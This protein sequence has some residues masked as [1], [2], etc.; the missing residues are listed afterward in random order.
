MTGTQNNKPA[1]A[2][3]QSSLRRQRRILLIAVIVTAVLALALV[4]TNFLTSREP[5]YDPVDNTKYYVVKKDGTYVLTATDG[6]VL[7][8]TESTNFVTA[9]GTIVNVDRK[10]GEYAIV[11]TVLV[12]GDETTKFDSVTNSYDVL[13]YPILERAQIKSIEVVNK[14]GG[15]SI[16]KIISDDGVESFVLKNRPDLEVGNSIVFATLI[17][18]TG[19]TQTLM[20]LDPDRVLGYEEYGLDTETTYFVITD[21]DGKSH[22]VIVGDEVPSGTGYYARYEGRDAVYVLR[23]FSGETEYNSTFERAIVNGTPEDYVVAPSS[24]HNVS[25]TNYFDV[26][27]FKL[28]TSENYAK[29]LVEFSYAGS[30]EKRRNTYYSNVPYVADGGMKGYN[31]N[32]ITVDDCLYALQQWSAD[33]VVAV[34]DASRTAELDDWLRPYGLSSDTYA[35]RLSYILN[36][37]RTYNSTT[38]K[39]VISKENDQ[40]YHEILISKKQDNG[41]YYAYNI[42]YKWDPETSSYSKVAPG[43]NMVVALTPSQVQFVTWDLEE[44]IDSSIFGGHISY[45]TKM[46]INI[47]PGDS[48]FPTGLS[49][50]LYLDNSA[51]LTQEP[52]Q[53]G[54]V[55]TNHMVIRDSN[56]VL[57]DTNQFKSFYSTLIYTP[58]ADYSSLSEAEQAA[59]RESGTAGA[60]M[61]IKMT[62]ELI[63]YDA[64]KKDYVSTGE[65]IVKE[66]CF[67]KSALYPREVYT[68]VNGVGDFYVV[69]SRIDKVI[70][71]LNRLYTGETIVPEDPF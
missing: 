17:N 57:I 43:Y 7:R 18:C 39:D 2:R 24:S 19:Y 31:I 11:A 50:I 20:R 60:Y 25:S 68:T 28:Y 37:A 4:L 69:R 32:S 56:A 64:E 5:F 14:N 63:E 66:Y 42:C 34:G 47:K 13:L 27:N 1:A 49:K 54:G 51:S 67:Y 40:E 58:L 65:V 44:W 55:P 71:D 21:M 59:F 36:L 12:E 10:T 23:E 16:G 46:E 45:M 62:Y 52:S 33:H 61:S 9:S 41:F 6:T 48:V 22:K 8:Q 30:I 26:T 35:Y 29:P 3:I 15:F 70:N 53:A 38:G